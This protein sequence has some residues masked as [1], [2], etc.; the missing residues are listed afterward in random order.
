MSERLIHVLF[1]LLLLGYLAYSE[2]RWRSYD[3]DHIRWDAE[4]AVCKVVPEHC[5]K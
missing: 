2:R 4:T 3:F 1:A 5:K